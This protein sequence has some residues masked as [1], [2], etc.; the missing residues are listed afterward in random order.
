MPSSALHKDHGISRCRSL[1]LCDIKQQD[2]MFARASSS[3]W[4]FNRS[5]TKSAHGESNAVPLVLARSARPS[6]AFWGRWT[7]AATP[8]KPRTIPLKGCTVLRVEQ[9]KQSRPELFD[10]SVH[11]DAGISGCCDM[12]GMKR[13]CGSSSCVPWMLL[14]EGSGMDHG[15]AVDWC[16]FSFFASLLVVE[17]GD[18]SES[19]EASG[20]RLSTHRNGQTYT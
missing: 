9:C 20:T 1:G 16:D 18:V 2:E 10:F 4:L 19:A 13:K 3:C 5:W 12:P 15:F 8:A 17:G 7:H 11:T 14:V 6:S